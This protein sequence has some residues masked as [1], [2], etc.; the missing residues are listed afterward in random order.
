MLLSLIALWTMVLFAMQAV[1]AIVPGGVAKLLLI[2]SALCICLFATAS[3]VAV[4]IHIR[5]N[6]DSI[7]LE[8]IRI[9]LD[10]K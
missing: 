5:K 3:L 10:Q 9:S 6:R 7:Y 1:A 8:D 2:A 4:Y